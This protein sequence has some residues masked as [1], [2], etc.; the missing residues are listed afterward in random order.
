VTGERKARTGWEGIA[1]GKSERGS[2]YAGHSNCRILAMISRDNT[3]QEKSIVL[4]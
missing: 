2:G 4:I 3:F 1:C